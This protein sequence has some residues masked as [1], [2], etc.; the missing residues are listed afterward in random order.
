VNVEGCIGAGRDGSRTTT[1]RPRVDTRGSGCTVES[2]QSG[3]AGPLYGGCTMGCALS[4]PWTSQVRGRSSRPTKEVQE[5]Q[6]R[7]Q[8]AS[9]VL[10]PV[11]RCAMGCARSAPWTSLRSVLGPVLRLAPRGMRRDA[12]WLA[13]TSTQTRAIVARVG[14]RLYGALGCTTRSPTTCSMPRGASAPVERP[15]G[16]T[17]APNPRCSLSPGCQ[18]GVGALWPAIRLFAPRCITTLTAAARRS[19]RA[20]GRRCP[21]HGTH[22]GAARPSRRGPPRRGRRR[23]CRPDRR[24]RPRG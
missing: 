11:L 12:R 3:L 7:G 5:D 23:S 15:R 17:I 1:R 9:S 2:E 13:G 18:P 14:Q 8:D 21:P 19:R 4:A 6:A 20:G 16:P 10:G 24:G 22:C